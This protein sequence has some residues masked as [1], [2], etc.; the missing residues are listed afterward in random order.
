MFQMGNHKVEEELSKETL[1]ECRRKTREDNRRK[2][3]RVGR[4]L[5]GLD[6]ELAVRELQR[7]NVMIKAE[8]SRLRAQL[9]KVGKVKHLVTL[10][11][12]SNEAIWKA[13]GPVS[14]WSLPNHE[15]TGFPHSPSDSLP[16][17]HLV[18]PTGSKKP[19]HPDPTGLAVPLLPP[20]SY[21][22]DVRATPNAE[23]KLFKETHEKTHE[24]KKQKRQQKDIEQTT[25][26]ANGATEARKCEKKRFRITIVWKGFKGIKSFFQK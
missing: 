20:L 7:E 26:E 11:C 22:S 18:S 21:H 4:Y 12:T 19:H 10:Q 2:A 17:L 25:K 15:T 9:E 24:K 23:K 14:P 1:G 5:G 6:L 13:Q 16:D 3:A 8:L